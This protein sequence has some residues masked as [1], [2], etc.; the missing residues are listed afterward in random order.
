MWQM[1]ES[2]EPDPTPHE[3]N[4]FGK[5]W[6]Y[7]QAVGLFAQSSLRCRAARESIATHIFLVEQIDT[8]NDLSNDEYHVKV[9]TKRCGSIRSMKHR[10]LEVH[11]YTTFWHN[12]SSISFFYAHTRTCF[13]Q[14]KKNCLANSDVKWQKSTQFLMQ[15]AQKVNKSTKTNVYCE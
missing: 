9:N 10:K 5:N 7:V 11:M 6:G 14:K 15:N 1:Y 4:Q 12:I 3:L 2:S 13:N 8:K